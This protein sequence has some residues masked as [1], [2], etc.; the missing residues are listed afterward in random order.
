MYQN[1]CLLRFKQEKRAHFAAQ[2]LTFWACR[3]P[4]GAGVFHAK[5]WGS[6]SSCPSSKV[7]FPWVAREGTWDVPGILSG[8]PGPLRVFKK[9]VQKLRLTFPRAKLRRQILMTGRNS[10]RRIGRNSGRRIVAPARFAEAR[11]GFFSFF[12]LLISDAGMQQGRPA[13][14]GCAL[15]WQKCS[16]VHAATSHRILAAWPRDASTQVSKPH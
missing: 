5:G 11:N 8:C 6:K 2:R 12:F 4:G 3:P 7:C 1:L 13:R 16:Q 10:G 14:R 9:F 15:P